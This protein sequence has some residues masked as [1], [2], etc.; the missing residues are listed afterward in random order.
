MEVYFRALTCIHYAHFPYFIIDAADQALVLDLI[1]EDAIMRLFTIYLFSVF[2]FAATAKSGQDAWDA[3]E[4]GQAPPP[5]PAPT[6]RRLY[7][8]PSSIAI[9]KSISERVHRE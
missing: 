9:E 5:T 6:T 4:R 3:K 1:Q 8:R 2:A 7:K